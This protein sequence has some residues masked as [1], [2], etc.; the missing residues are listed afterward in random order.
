MSLLKLTDATIKFG[1]LVAV[2][3]VSFELN[4]GDLFGL[5]GP[6]GAGKTTCFNIITGVY[7]PTSGSI[8]FDGKDITGTPSNKIAK[9]GICRTFQ[10]IR[11]FQSLSSL[12]NVVVGGFLRHK[13]V[14]GSAL[15]YLPSAIKETEQLKAQA[16][17][18]LRL[19]DLEDVANARSRD[20]PYG[21]QRRL[22][23]ARALATQPKLLLLDEPAA[24]MNPQEKM[25]LLTMVKKIRDELG[26]TVLLI[27]H[28]MKFVMNL[29]ERIFVLDHGEEIAQGPPSEIR[30]DPKVIAAYLGEAV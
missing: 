2:N 3:K 4:K 12:E 8:V 21:K 13:T 30:N 23:I 26:V 14:L 11:L 16:L 1:G 9:R 28:D 19:L 18:L 10:N 29:C 15:T 25:E 20:L 22:E 7:A 17:D 24:G 5:I 6:N 27:E